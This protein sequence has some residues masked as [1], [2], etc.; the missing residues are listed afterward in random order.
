M[1]RSLK[2]CFAASE[3]APFAKTGGLADVASAL[4]AELHRLGHEVQLYLPLHAAIDREA[5]AIEPYEAIQGVELEVGWRRVPFS[6]GRVRLPGSE[7]RAWVVDCPELFDRPEVYTGKRDEAERFLVF[8]RAIIESC[9]RQ[10]WAPDVFHLND[11]HTALIPF[12]LR[13]VYEWDSL[14]KASRSLM[15]IHNIGYQG[16]FPAEIV[17]ELGLGQW[18]QLLDQDDLQAGRVN[19]LRTGLIYADAISTVSPTYAREIQTEEFGMGLEQVLRARRD[20]LVGILNGVDYE[21][22]SPERDP[23][24]PFRFSKEDLE[25]KKRNKQHLLDTLGLDPNL[26]APLAGIISRLAHQK[27]FEL[28][29]DVLP[30]ALSA[31]DLR[32]VALGSGEKKYERFFNGLQQRFPGRVCYHR[33]YNDELSH[34]IEAG[35]DLFLM[36]SRYEPCGLNQMFSMRYGTLPVA[37]KT[38]GLADSVTQ[39]DA[40]RAKGTGFLFGHFSADGLRWA[41]QR[42]LEC[43]KDQE[44]WRRLM[45]N[46]M[47]ESFSWEDQ[48]KPYV[49]LYGKLVARGA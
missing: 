28:C 3:V 34:A 10:G 6:L 16:V 22:W 9:Q 17:E 42:A 21:T 31:T 36:P 25:G 27:G 20:T 14:F 12:L 43:W 18:S 35:A 37:R 38:G 24:I 47:R 2:V 23:H 1:E 33:G 30:E 19:F 44:L 40:A 4:P 13:S 29:F 32:L 15:T 5:Y 49:E 41:L 46:A 26:G 39:V 48:A 8:A 45:L 11:W 7:L